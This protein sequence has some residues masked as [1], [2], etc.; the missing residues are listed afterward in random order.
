[1]MSTVVVVE[2]SVERAFTIVA[3]DT[4]LVPWLSKNY[5][6]FSIV[7]GLAIS[8]PIKH[9]VG[10][11]VSLQRIYALC[12]VIN[13]DLEPVMKLASP[14]GLGSTA[15]SCQSPLTDYVGWD[16]FIGWVNSVTLSDMVENQAVI[17]KENSKNH[18]AFVRKVR[19]A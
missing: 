17:P 8:N 6:L 2:S 1:M 9:R 15:V 7:D 12:T 5:P 14:W 11:R 16:N 10:F 4:G 13:R 3:S 19:L 18:R